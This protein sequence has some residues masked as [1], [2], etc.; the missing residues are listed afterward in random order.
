[1][2]DDDIWNKLRI[3]PAKLTTPYV[4]AK[5]KKRGEQFIKVPMWWYEKLAN[6]APRCRCT[7]LVAWYLLHLNWKN[8][9]K[10]FKL[11]NGMLAYDGIS[12]DSKWRALK[13]LGRRGLISVEWRKKKSPIIHVRA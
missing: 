4:P 3:D 13:D 5:I 2:H 7:C 8:E 1:M 9:G 6:P 10:P 11:P 12:P